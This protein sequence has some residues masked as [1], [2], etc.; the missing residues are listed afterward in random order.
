RQLIFQEPHAPSESA[1]TLQSRELAKTVAASFAQT[2]SA[3]DT[4]V[5]HCP[6]S[7]RRRGRGSAPAGAQSVQCDRHW[8][9][10]AK[11]HS[12]HRSS[13]PHKNSLPAPKLL[14]GRPRSV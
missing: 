7:S 14:F 5:C 9:G 13:G 10:A 11:A 1:I 12:L 8:P 6:H 3:C 4:F 2:H